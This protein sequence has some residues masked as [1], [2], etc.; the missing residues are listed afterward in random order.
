MWSRLGP[1]CVM[2]FV[3]LFCEQAYNRPVT[4]PRVSDTRHYRSANWKLRPT[5]ASQYS[6]FSTV[7]VLCAGNSGIVSANFKA[8]RR[9]YKYPF[10]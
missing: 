2:A 9:D 6:P 4:H 1:Q 10:G 8:K 7:V 5:T 3:I